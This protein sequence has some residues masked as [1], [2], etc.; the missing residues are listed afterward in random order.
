MIFEYPRRRQP[1]RNYLSI[2]ILITLLA[3]TI[4]VAA[5]EE[6]PFLWLEDVE[7]EKALEW[8][9]ARSA[10]DTAEIEAVPEFAGL[11]ERLLE[12][13]NSSD[14]IPNPGIRGAWIYNFWQDADH[15]RGIWR[16]TFLSEYV[17][18]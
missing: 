9:K 14:R 8:V 11:H 5:D 2:T 16:R 7:G 10:A 15:V 3:T 1:M 6:D 12:I 17:K 4:A 13:Y 18:E